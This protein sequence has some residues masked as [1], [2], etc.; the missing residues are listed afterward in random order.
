MSVDLVSGGNLRG[1]MFKQIHCPAFDL[2]MAGAFDGGLSRCT[3][4]QTSL[5]FKRFAEVSWTTLAVIAK[6]VIAL[7]GYSEAL[8]PLS[9]TLIPA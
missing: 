4:W 7:A 8:A 5:C 2:E 9:R 6:K 1:R 3:A